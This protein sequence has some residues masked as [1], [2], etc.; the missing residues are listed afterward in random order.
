VASAL[1]VGDRRIVE[2]IN[3]KGL[4]RALAYVM[5]HGINFFNTADIDDIG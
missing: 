3:D 5:D 2:K 1:A 4:L